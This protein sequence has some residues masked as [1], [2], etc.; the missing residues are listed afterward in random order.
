MRLLELAPMARVPA[1]DGADRRMWSLFQASV[2]AG[3]RATFLGREVR[4]GLDGR[5]VR[6]GAAPG[7]RKRKLAVALVAMAGGRDYWRTK[8]ISGKYRNLVRIEEKLSEYDIVNIHFLFASPLFNHFR[9]RRLG[10]TIDTHNYDPDVFGF[11][12]DWARDP[13][14]RLLAGRAARM[15]VESVA[16]LP[17][18]T[19]MIHVSEADAK[20]YT[21]LRPDLRHE[22]I[23]NGCVVR[24]RARGPDYTAKTKVLAFV[25]SLSAKMNEDAL[26]NF[27]TEFWPV[28]QGDATVVVA[29]SNPSSLVIRICSANGWRLLPNVSEEALDQ[30]YEAAHFGVLPFQYGAGSKL[31]LLEACGRGVPVLSTRAGVGGVHQIPASIFVGE[32]P[33]GWLQM[34]RD[35]GP[36]QSRIPEA[37]AFAERHT[38]RVLGERRLR[39]LESCAPVTWDSSTGESS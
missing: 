39:L 29:G 3:A 24:P 37:T 25:G 22:V 18:G 38:W 35:P 15:S 19:V 27:A 10:L 16:G 34:L 8:F 6:H 33:G 20:A 7:W 13:V 14:T 23:E 5:I 32:D 12:R 30:I 17:R 26:A 36:L 9:G 21:A 31:K 28:L 1:M 2:A 11:Y 4:V